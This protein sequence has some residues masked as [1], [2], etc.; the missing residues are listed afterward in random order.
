MTSEQKVAYVVA[1]AAAA[2]AEVEAM[3]AANFERTTNGFALAYDENAFINVIYK[4]GLSMNSLINL[5][6]N[7]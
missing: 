3:K 6:N 7:A 2:F 5:F 1:Q 4:Y